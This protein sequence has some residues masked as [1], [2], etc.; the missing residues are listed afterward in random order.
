MTRTA[1]NGTVSPSVI[2]AFDI[3]ASI[4]LIGARGTG[5]SSLAHIASSAFHMTQIDV[6]DAFQNETGFSRTTFRK[7]HGVLQSRER[8]LSLL[9][10]ILSNHSRNCVIVCPGDYTEEA[11]LLLL[12]HYADK[13][14]VILV[15]RSLT[16]IQEYLRPWDASKVERLLRLVQPLYRSCSSF[17]FFN[18]DECEGA[19]T[20]PQSHLARIELQGQKP[21]SLRLKHLEQAFIHFMNNILPPSF[22]LDEPQGQFSVPN[23]HAVYTY[24]LRISNPQLLQDDF[25]MA[26]LD[27]GADACQLEIT[28]PQ[29][30]HLSSVRSCTEDATR[31]F[32]IARKYFDGPII[33]HVQ[34]P[35]SSNSSVLAQY[36]HLLQHGLRLGA[37]YLTINLTLSQ[38]NYRSLLPT[39]NIAKLIGDY[40]DDSPGS[41]GWSTQKRWGLLRT[42][43][44]LGLHGLRLTQPALD[45]E[46]NRAVTHFVVEAGRVQGRKPFLIAY[47]TT[48]LG[49]PSQCFNRAL[50]PITTADLQDGV[51]NLK[52]SLALDPPLTIQQ[53]Q[54]ALYAS[55]TF[56]GMKFFIIGI[57]VSYSLSPIIHNAAH[58]FFG[59]PHHLERRSMPSL[60]SIDE[61]V[62]HHRTGG[63]SVAQGYKVSILPRL[64]AISDHARKIGAINTLIPIRASWDYTK[65]PT[66]EFWATR[67][68]PGPVLG[69][70][71]D[72][73]D[74]V[75]MRQCVLQNL[76]PANVVTPKTTALV[77]GAGGMARAAFYAMLQMG[78]RQI[79]M[80]NRTLENAMR[81]AQHFSDLGMVHIPDSTLQRPDSQTEVDSQAK[82]EVRFLTSSESNWFSDLA[83]PTIIIACIPASPIAGEPAP[84]FILPQAWIMSPT[85]G[86]VL[87]LNY[88]PLVTPLLRQ[89]REQSAKGWVAVDGLEN[90]AAQ[91]S[92][93]FKVLTSRKVPKNL[94]RIEALK[95]CL[96][97]YG[98]DEEIC[99]IIQSQLAQLHATT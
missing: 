42:A 52:E 2:H 95:H 20:G 23:T 80:L 59:M 92:A 60:D 68:R 86:V 85:G 77:V 57:D 35:T 73:L 82:A 64:S 39:K 43:R 93:Q 49:R 51:L 26:W 6:N 91:A 90:L 65:P 36:V 27:C 19:A 29:N 83:Q 16:A 7:Q 5:K 70:Y 75:G 14:P 74:W 38:E 33:Y 46:D 53:L 21:W 69:L 72:N 47:N 22:T 1:S 66:A 81:L 12:K 44:D 37:D 96:A 78:V 25:N 40:H 28:L 41:D 88:R 56:S 9:R 13:H 79:V 71:G 58:E 99:K 97:T 45:P 15:T 55:F 8:E 34:L 54:K 48:P 67:T 61:L 3:D 89:V 31:G 32:A 18:L 62:Q 10:T 50:T 17:E 76:S 63:L 30:Q 11:G 24:L 4:V 87:D 84:D 98:D 94:M